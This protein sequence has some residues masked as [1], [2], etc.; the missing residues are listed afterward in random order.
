MRTMRTVFMVVGLL[1]IMSQVAVADEAEV[2]MGISTDFD[3]QELTIQVAS[4]G[5]TARADF[6]FEFKDEI[7]TIHRKKKDECKA[8]ES[9]VSLTF[10]LKEAGLEANKSFKLG[11]RLIVNPMLA[12][13]VGR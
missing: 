12:N 6:L 13:S 11:N 3:K 8:M 10:S 2:L 7:L 5:C 4:S 1:A 9:A